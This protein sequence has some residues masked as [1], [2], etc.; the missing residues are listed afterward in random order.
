MRYLEAINLPFN[1]HAIKDLYIP[2]KPGEPDAG[3]PGYWAVV[4]ED[5]VVFRD[6]DGGFDLPEGR[7]PDHLKEGGEEVIIGRWKGRPLRLLKIGNCNDVPTGFIAEPLLMLFLKGKMD[8]SLLTVAGLA[9]Q[10]ARWEANSEACPR[11][12]ARTGR[13]AGSWGKYCGACSYE[14]F[15]CIHPCAIALV[16]RGDSLLMISK[17]EWPKGYYSLPSGFCDFGEC[18]EECVVREVEE[19][20]GIRAKNIR[21]LGSQSWPFPSQLMAGFAAEYESGEIVVDTKEL[22]DARWFRRDSM[23]PTF[24]AKSIAGWM[25]GG[26]ADRA[27]P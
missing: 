9:Q 17:P 1:N 19:E 8:D 24:S 6:K 16:T 10:I 18:L 27:C 3:E 15:P 20:T 23:P 2:A 25:I 4:R 26:F 7:L 12:G 11:C 22:E 5:C 13:I 14:H 21:Y